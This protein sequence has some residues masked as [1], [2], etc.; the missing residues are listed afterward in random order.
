MLLEKWKKL[1]K[2]QFEPETHNIPD[3]M[4]IVFVYDASWGQHEHRHM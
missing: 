1:H 3:S 2:D 4:E